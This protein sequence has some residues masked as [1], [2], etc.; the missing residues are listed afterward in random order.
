MSATPLHLTAEQARYL[1]VSGSG[2]L[3]PFASPTQ[4]AQSLIGIQAQILPAAGLALA[5]RLSHLSHADLDRLLYE[6][7][8][9]VKLW[10]QRGTLHLYASDDWP[11]ICAARSREQTGWMRRLAG[12]AEAAYQR[13]VEAVAA[14]L[15]E[16]ETIGRSDLRE[17]E[18]PLS[19][20][21]L[22]PWGGVFAE[23][24]RQ[25][26]ACHVARVGGEGRFAHRERWLPDL[27]WSPPNA[28]DANLVIARRY[29]RAYAPASLAD[30]AYWRAV[31]QQAAQA[32]VTA[33]EDELVDVTIIDGEEVGKVLKV[34]SARLD[35]LPAQLPPPEAWPVHLLYRFDPLLLGQRDK[36]W[37]IPPRHDKRVRRPAGHI[38]GVILDHGTTAATWRYERKGR[39]L[40]IRVRPFRRL[41]RYVTKQLPRLATGVA[42]FFDLA[43]G[44]LTVERVAR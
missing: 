32:W 5:N 15:A 31:P 17:S 20:G 6:D 41:P 3:A 29:F 8:A 36:G 25:G 24:V 39:T 38:E 19:D 42:D 23:L 10:G 16:R 43:L 30:F 35:T 22:S 37:V 13:A 1:R 33:I 7:R 18:I 40:N 14:L 2:L 27:A 12:D 26:Y 44:D 11:L 28:E 34:A 21:M 4:A 9:L